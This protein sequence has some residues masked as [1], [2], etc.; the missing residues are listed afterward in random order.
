MLL[1]AGPPDCTSSR[2][3]KRRA[4]FAIVSQ[5]HNRATA[6]L[7]H[8]ARALHLDAS[9]EDLLLQ[10]SSR[11]ES[12]TSRDSDQPFPSPSPEPSWQPWP[13]FVS[14]ETPLER[15]PD[16]C[17]NLRPDGCHAN[18]A[19]RGGLR[20]HLALQKLRSGTLTT[21]TRKLARNSCGGWSHS[22]FRTYQLN[23]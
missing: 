6:A 20:G 22:R 23:Y 10:H 16:S 2:K 17:L 19:L 21:T 8:A 15:V 1:L 18:D 3:T 4:C 9:D 7:L 14:A 11:S 5:R 12:A 13:S